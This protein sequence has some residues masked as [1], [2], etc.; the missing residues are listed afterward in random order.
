MVVTQVVA[1]SLPLL[2]FIIYEQPLN[3][4]ISDNPWLKGIVNPE[5]KMR[6]AGQQP[7]KSCLASL[8]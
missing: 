6:S 3:T 1:S 8:G 5:L 7:F 2:C 4:S